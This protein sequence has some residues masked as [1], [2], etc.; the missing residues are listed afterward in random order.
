MARYNRMAGAQC[1][2]FITAA[3]ASFARKP[4]PKPD[5]YATTTYATDG[6]CH[7]AEQGTFGHECGKP[8]TWIGTQETGFRSG[9][10]DDCKAHG[11]EAKGRTWTRVAA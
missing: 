5:L 8:A 10:C 9:F 1:D 3:V 11:W 6:L 7:N 2:L 4:E